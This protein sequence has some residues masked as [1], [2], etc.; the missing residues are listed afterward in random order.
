[1]RYTDILINI[2]KLVRSINLESKRIQKAHGVSI[3]QL[4]CMTFLSE[5]D[6][7]QSTS[8]EISRYLNL[9]MSTTSGIIN[10]LEKKALVARLPKSGDKRVTPVGLTSKGQ[11]LLNASPELIHEQLTKKLK[12]LPTEEIEQ[13]NTVLA[14]LVGYLKLEGIEASAMITIE[15]P[16]ISIEDPDNVI[17]EK[18]KVE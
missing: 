1:M 12:E 11:K 13:I 18:R 14:K 17:P 8:T 7:Y 3:P 2:R 4:L 9:N 10:R 5:K 6:N 16:I 15:E